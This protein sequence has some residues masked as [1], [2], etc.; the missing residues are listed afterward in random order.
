[1]KV[2]NSQVRDLLISLKRVHTVYQK[3]NEEQRGRLLAASE[4]LFSKLEA[5]GFERSFL[6]TLVISGKDFIDSLYG[7]GGE[8]ATENDGQIIFS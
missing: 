4:K 8:E 7:E 6:E 3:A 2:G 1:M 5:Q